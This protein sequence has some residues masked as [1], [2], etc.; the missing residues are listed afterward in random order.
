M[1]PLNRYLFGIELNARCMSCPGT[2]YWIDYLM[3]R[4]RPRHPDQYY[5]PLCDEEDF[6]YFLEERYYLRWTP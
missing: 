4:Q 6:T 1:D 2:A 3:Y 5:C